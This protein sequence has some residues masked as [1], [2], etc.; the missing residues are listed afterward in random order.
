METP[1]DH[2]E[3]LAKM[4]RA[5]ANTYSFLITFFVA[6]DSFTYGFNSAI[7]ASVLGLEWFSTYFDLSSDNPYTGAIT[8]AINGIYTAGGAID[9]CIVS[10]LS[11]TL[12]RRPSIKIISALCILSAALQAGSVYSFRPPSW[13]PKQFTNEVL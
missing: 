6:Q 7:V 10:W 2:E 8:G 5:K 11:N 9:C 3:N 13:L 4:A 12:G 1:L